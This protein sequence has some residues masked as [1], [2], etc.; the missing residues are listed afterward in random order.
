MGKHLVVS[1]IILFIFSTLF[2]TT[3]IEAVS[4]RQFDFGTKN[5]PVA[6]GYIKVTSLTLYTKDN[7]FGWLALEG[8][9][10][11]DRGK[12]DDLL[13]DFVYSG[14]DKT[15]AVSLPDGI[16]KVKV[17][18][19][20]NKTSHDGI[21]ITAENVRVV[22]YLTVSGGRFED[23]TFLVEV[24]DG[25]LTLT[26]SDSGGKDDLWVINA[27][28]IT[29][30]SKEEYKKYKEMLA[31][32]PL[33]SDV[34]NNTPIGT[35]PIYWTESSGI[36]Q[37]EQDGEVHDKGTSNL[38][39]CQSGTNI[40]GGWC[41]S[42]AGESDWTDYIV[43]AKVKR[44][45]SSSGVYL[46]FRVQDPANYYFIDYY[47]G[48]HGPSLRWRKREA[49]AYTD[50]ATVSNPPMFN[51]NNWYE[52]KVIIKGN[53]IELYIDGVKYMDATDPDNTFM[54]GYIGLGSWSQHVHFDDVRVEPIQL[55]EDW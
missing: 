15:F 32:Q 5:S 46:F 51:A 18:I 36:W 42:F 55:E 53:A 22:R 40:P 27:L 50:I 34:F 38:I 3:N 43:K 52:M 47:S 8:L 21:S 4:S 29:E 30:G 26:F 31:S 16:Y 39:Y 19:G 35:S 2:I 41:N 48:V 33:F 25:E 9:H 24:N 17:S 10:D 7:G 20:D 1:G 12:P 23:K 37:V 44:F 14:F 54:K 28:T 49:G 45:G 11:F 6:A 13:R